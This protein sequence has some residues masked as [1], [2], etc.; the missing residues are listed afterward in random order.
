MSTEVYRCLI[1]PAAHA[2]LARSLAEAL[3]PVTGAGMWVTP[4]SPTGSPP[5]THYFS[6][7]NI[8]ANLAALLPLI[9][10]RADAD[11]WIANWLEAGQPET[12]HQ[13]A[14]H[15]GLVVPLADIEA[16]LAES[17]IT[18]EPSTQARAR[19]ALSWVQGA[20]EPFRPA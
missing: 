7:G 5:I 9:E 20:E 4:L 1:V 17:D 14:A 3:A 8:S 11:T 2:P 15:A 19:L 12:L 18:E 13:L 16:L 6:A 10:Y